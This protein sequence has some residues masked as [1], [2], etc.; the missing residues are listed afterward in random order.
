M[1]I[2][3]DNCCY[4]RPFDDQSQDKI[5]YEAAAVQN[6]VV[7]AQCYGHTIFESAVLDIEI[8]KIKNKDVGKYADVLGGVV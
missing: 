1:K 3:F 6:I 4:G 7:I 2:Y 8:G 5:R